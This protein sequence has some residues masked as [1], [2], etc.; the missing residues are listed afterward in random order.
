[1]FDVNKDTSKEERKLWLDGLKEG[2]EVCF[3]NT[4]NFA[5]SLF[6]SAF[7]FSM[8]GGSVTDQLEREKAEAEGKEFCKILNVR[9]RLSD[10]SI[11]VDDIVFTP[12]GKI[13]SVAR[14]QH[15]ALSMDG[16][17]IPVTD[18]LREK[19]SRLKFEDDIKTIN[20][21]IIDLKSIQEIVKIINTA[22]AKY[23]TEHPVEDK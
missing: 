14:S 10:G 20:W 3:S 7:G 13:E 8:F 12:E 2:D 15:S 21:K 9:G 1:M 18:E 6:G 4:H 19:A 22:S 16:E 5:R 17:L 23:I 11:V